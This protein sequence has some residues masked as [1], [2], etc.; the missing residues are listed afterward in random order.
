M[1]SK[2]AWFYIQEALYDY[3]YV[4]HSRHYQLY[5]FKDNLEVA[6][7]QHE[8]S[9]NFHEMQIKFDKDKTD[10][11]SLSA[12]Q[13]ISLERLNN[14]TMSSEEGNYSSKKIIFNL[15]SNNLQSFLLFLFKFVKAKWR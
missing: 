13:D 5:G 10:Q 1:L 3:K 2:K 4:R 14:V 7:R 9:L 15:I 11:S 8:A 12:T 6:Q